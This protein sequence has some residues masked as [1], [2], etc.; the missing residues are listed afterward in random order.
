MFKAE[1]WNCDDCVA[2]VAGVGARVG[3]VVLCFYFSYLFLV[4]CFV[5]VVVVP[6]AVVSF[7]FHKWMDSTA[8]R[9]A[10]EEAVL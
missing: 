7:G 1:L 6:V 3:S 2:A 10:I 8:F 4:F 9:V 5:V